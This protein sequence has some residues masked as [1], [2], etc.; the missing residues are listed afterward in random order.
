MLFNNYC[1]K[2]NVP[3]RLSKVPIIPVNIFDSEDLDMDIRCTIGSV[4]RQDLRSV[5]LS[6]TM[7][8]SDSRSTLY[9]SDGE[10]TDDGNDEDSYGKQYRYV[11][12]TLLKFQRRAESQ[13]GEG[14]LFYNST[15]TCT[16]LMNALLNNRQLDPLSRNGQVFVI[17]RTAL[18]KIFQRIHLRPK[19]VLQIQK[20]V[21]ASLAAP[22]RLLPVLEVWQPSIFASAAWG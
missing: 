22:R 21:V 8:E 10:D 5:T 9:I 17:A 4:P 3:R 7:S 19:L 15:R 14:F 20:H 16:K 13:L 2:G 18:A 12:H 11:P 6:S 1:R